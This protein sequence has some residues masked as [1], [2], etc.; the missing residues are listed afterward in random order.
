LSLVVVDVDG[1]VVEEGR[2]SRFFFRL[3]SFFQALGRGRQHP[4][5]ELIRKLNSQ[6]RV[7]VLTGRN[8]KDLEFTKAQLRKAGLKFEEVICA[9]RREV[10]T[11]WKIE[12]VRKMAAEGQ[13]VW[14]DDMFRDRTAKDS[15]AATGVVLN[16]PEEFAGE[17]PKQSES[18]FDGL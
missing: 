4:D 3:A 6:S 16:T 18:Q 13:V 14:V 9:P 12:T 11:T 8:A 7:V 1:T 15:A 17:T 10:L 2:L 5:R